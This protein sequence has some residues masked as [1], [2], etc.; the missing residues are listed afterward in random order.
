MLYNLCFQI[1]SFILRCSPSLVVVKKIDINVSS[2][3]EGKTESETLILFMYVI[4]VCRVK[5]AISIA[6]MNWQIS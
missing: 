1:Q 3:T 4:G 2:R 6:I 5:L